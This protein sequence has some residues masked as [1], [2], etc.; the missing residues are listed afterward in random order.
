VK[1]EKR[2]WIGWVVKI[3]MGVNYVTLGGFGFDVKKLP[4]YEHL[5]IQ[6]IEE[7][8]FDDYEEF[9]REKKILVDH[10]HSI[11]LFIKFL[12][13]HLSKAMAKKLK[14]VK[15]AIEGNDFNIKVV[16]IYTND[17]KV[18]WKTYVFVASTHW[19]FNLREAV[20]VEKK[21]TRPK[22]PIVEAIR[23]LAPEARLIVVGSVC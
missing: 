17:E 21:I 11:S 5:N 8:F 10:E 18:L 1:S 7:Y 9:L 14:A 23:L 16:Q 4:F 6:E 20:F 12:E 22:K 13:A 19:E 2:K 3:V 15:Q